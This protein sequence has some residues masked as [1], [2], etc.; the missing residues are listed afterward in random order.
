MSKQTR[1]KLFIYTCFGGCATGIAAAKACIRL[2]KENPDHVKIACLPAVIVPGKHKEMLESSEKRMLIDACGLKCGAKLFER[3]VMPVDR[4][5]E[6]T[7][8][9][10]LRKEKQLPSE[11]LEE[12]VYKAVLNEVRSL[13]ATSSKREMQSE[14]KR[15]TRIGYDTIK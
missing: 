14:T 6:L 1:W 5:L 9:L 13:L 3:E 12:Q 4:Y 11:D 15:S 10:K 7:S 8:Q 2:W